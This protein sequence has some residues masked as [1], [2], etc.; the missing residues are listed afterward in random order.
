MPAETLREQYASAPPLTDARALVAW[1]R[2]FRGPETV[3]VRREAEDRAISVLDESAGAMNAEQAVALG[4][5]FNT[6]SRDGELRHDRFA[7][8]F[9]G[10]TWQKVIEDLDL[11]NDR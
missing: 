4:R 8:A 6:D 7:P 9:H 2:R 11:F 3:R 1:V 5:L 10:A